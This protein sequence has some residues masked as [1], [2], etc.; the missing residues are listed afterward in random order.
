MSY[1][2]VFGGIPFYLCL[3][4]SRLSIDQNINELFF[5]E[6]GELRYEYDHLFRSLFQKPEKHVTIVNTLCFRHNG[7]TRTELVKKSR[8]D[9]DE[10]LTRVLNE[11][12]ECG[13]IRKYQNYE[14]EESGNFYQVIDPFILFCN[15]FMPSQSSLNWLSYIHTPEYYAWRG[16]AFEI[17]CLNHIDQIKDRLGI[18]GIE[19]NVY[20]WRST[21]S[22]PAVQ[23]DLLIDRRDD[24]INHCEMKFTN[25]P[26]TLSSEEERKLLTRMSTFQNETRTRKAIH[27]TLVSAEGITGNIGSLTR[28]ITGEDLFKV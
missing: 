5:K 14:K 28:V 19:S 11:L 3:I 25:D 13:F 10:S 12:M 15:R 16:L 18:S 2:L 6:H 9:D 8:V 1:Y 24:V 20:S 26:F 17:L 23:I 27:L 22:Q 4:D 7:M 21:N